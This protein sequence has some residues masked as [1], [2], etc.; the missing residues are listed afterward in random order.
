VKISHT[1][2]R[3]AS[4]GVLNTLLDAGVFAGLHA[5]G[6]SIV[7][8]NFVS[9][10]VGLTS[11]L[12]LNSRYTFKV[13]RLTVQQVTLFVGINLIGLWV[14]QPLLIVAILYGLEHVAFLNSA[15]KQL[16]GGSFSA[17]FIASLIAT[18]GTF[19]WNYLLYSHVVYLPKSHKLSSGHTS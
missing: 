12:L 19:L 9:S 11:S 17:N 2:V 3:F 5:S 14:L 18:V 8:A 6:V 10:S 13:R 4:I 7:V 15:I 16:G 1:F